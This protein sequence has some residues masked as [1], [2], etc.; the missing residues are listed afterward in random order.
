VSAGEVDLGFLTA[1]RVQ[2]AIQ[3]ALDA[4]PADVKAERVAWCQKNDQHGVTMY[5]SDAGIDLQW[6]GQR[7]AFIDADALTED[8]LL[9]HG[10]DG[11][12]VD[13]S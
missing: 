8:A 9:F 2:A 10:I 13:P 3:A 1:Q 7:L 4:M 11:D 5:R 6:A 12:E